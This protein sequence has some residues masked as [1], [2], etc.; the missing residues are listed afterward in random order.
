[1][2]V[3]PRR[4]RITVDFYH[5]LRKGETAQSPLSY[6]NRSSLMVSSVSGSFDTEL[7]AKYSQSSRLPSW[8]YP[9]HFLDVEG[10]ARLVRRKA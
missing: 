2:G 4:S 8:K 5:A 3:A 9:K 7:G 10:G 1:M 6:S